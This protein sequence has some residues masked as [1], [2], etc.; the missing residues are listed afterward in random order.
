MSPE[1][2]QKVR[3]ID[4]HDIQLWANANWR[5]VFYNSLQ[6]LEN[7]SPGNVQEIA[8]SQ[9]GMLATYHEIA[10]AQSRRSF[11]WAL[12]GSGVGL[13]F[14]VA[15]VILALITGAL[16]SVISA[17]SGVAFEAVSGL[18]FW[19]YGRTSS[20]LS[21]F[22]S[23]LDQTQRYLLAN[24]ICES[25]TGEER[26][27]ARAE[28]IRAIAR[29]RTGTQNHDGQAPSEKIVARAPRS[30]KKGPETDAKESS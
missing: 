30:R 26:N 7:A 18:V 14:L 1:S 16:S 25:L 9:I 22:H 24:S 27:R 13:V 4:P 29:P 10:L 19:L 3:W 11:W 20:Q 15:A 28:L 17:L 2:D 23:T 5:N 21:S 8:A 6:G 12:V